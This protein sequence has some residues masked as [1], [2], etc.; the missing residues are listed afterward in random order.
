[1]GTI[2]YMT[3][4]EWYTEYEHLTFNTNRKT[5]LVFT[6]ENHIDS[7]EL[8]REIGRASCRERVLLIV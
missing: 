6:R 8:I 2:K 5:V 4:Y 1:M 7:L 3:E